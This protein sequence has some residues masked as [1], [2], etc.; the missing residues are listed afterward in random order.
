MFA[1]QERFIGEYIARTIYNI[2]V[3][4]PQTNVIQFIYTRLN[5]DILCIPPCV[6]IKFKYIKLPTYLKK[7]IKIT[8]FQPNFKNV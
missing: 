2:I 3:V 7:S 8:V 6:Y 5:I 1:V 4:H